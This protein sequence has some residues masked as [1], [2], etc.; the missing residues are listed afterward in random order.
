MKHAA[1]RALFAYWN[2]LRGHR[3]APERTHIDPTAIRGVLS[4]TFILEVDTRR[5]FPFRIAGTRANALFARE[6]KGT[7]FLDLWRGADLDTARRLLSTI[8]DEVSPSVSGLA[9]L[10]GDRTPL[11]IEL[12]L[13]PLRHNG[14]THARLLGCLSPGAV[15]AWL[16]LIPI[17]RLS[18]RS[19]RFVRD[20]PDGDETRLD[21]DGVPV[22][23]RSS[24]V[25][26]RPVPV[27]R[28]H[29]TVHRSGG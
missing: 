11:D 5:T 28:G 6:L 21:S 12:L 2:E 8:L 26:T 3:A 27:R 17:D 10:A 4:D 20:D 19:L 25:V 18:F 15:P 7:S 1:T 9:G 23:L 13:L 24:F 14:R 29:L 16:G 22:V